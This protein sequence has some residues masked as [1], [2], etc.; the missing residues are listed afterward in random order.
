MNPR[1]YAIQAAKVHTNDVDPLEAKV[2]GRLF[3][4]AVR[5]PTQISRS[6]AVIEEL[7]KDLEEKET[8][9]KCCVVM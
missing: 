9:P 3:T 5:A 8:N 4:P 2:H 7:A 1:I 6:F